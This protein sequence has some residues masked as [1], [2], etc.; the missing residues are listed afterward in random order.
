MALERNST[1]RPGASRTEQQGPLP[2]HGP[3]PHAPGQ[4]KYPFK[5]RM[6]H[7]PS[8]WDAEVKPKYP[9][10]DLVIERP[11]PWH[12]VQ[13]EIPLALNGAPCNTCISN[14]RDYMKTAARNSMRESRFRLYR[15]PG[16]GGHHATEITVIE[17]V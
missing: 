4:E 11:Y 3:G 7:D 13:R 8:H 5:Y 10:V 14:G 12:A 1:D 16:Q 6:S 2:Q 17:L 9:D 15:L